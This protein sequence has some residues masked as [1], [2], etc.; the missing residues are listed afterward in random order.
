MK[1]VGHR[2]SGG[3]HRIRLLQRCKG[4]RS[5]GFAQ[6]GHDPFDRST[7]RRAELSE[8]LLDSSLSRPLRGDGTKEGHAEDALAL[9]GDEGR[10][11]LR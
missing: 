7:A 9:G 2:G 10:G 11:K 8:S 1:N 3:A 5:S 4:L 6:T